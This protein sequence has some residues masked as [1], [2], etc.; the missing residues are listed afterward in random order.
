MSLQLGS[1]LFQLG[2]HQLGLGEIKSLLDRQGS[3]VTDERK[4]TL[5]PVPEKASRTGGVRYKAHQDDS[6]LW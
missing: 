2:A 4:Q 5:I 1:F 3:I 6:H